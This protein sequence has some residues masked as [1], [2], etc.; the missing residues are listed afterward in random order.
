MGGGSNTGTRDIQKGTSSA[1]D[2][3]RAAARQ[4][5]SPKIIKQVT[6]GGGGGGGGPSAGTTGL[7]P[8]E[9]LVE[10]RGDPSADAVNALLRR[11]RLAVLERL[12]FRL[13]VSAHRRLVIWD[14]S[15]VA[16]LVRAE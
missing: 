14:G 16:D 12:A 11:Y 3:K 15:A 5:S 7:V 9:V 6:T 4:A 10:L 1:K 8:N 13:T 2:K